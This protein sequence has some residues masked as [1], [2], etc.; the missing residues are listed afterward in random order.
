M[1]DPFVNVHSNA[2]AIIWTA[3][4]ATPESAAD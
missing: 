1:A 4:Q 2:S 3:E